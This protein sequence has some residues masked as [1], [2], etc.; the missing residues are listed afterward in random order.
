M[1]LA[2]KQTVNNAMQSGT[3]AGN[4]N[5]VSISSPAIARAVVA[6]LLLKPN[7]L[8]AAIKKALTNSDGSDRTLAAAIERMT[9]WADLTSLVIH[10]LNAEET[11]WRRAALRYCISRQ[12]HYALLKKLFKVSRDEVS[13]IRTELGNAVETRP[14]CIPDSELE[15]IYSAWRDICLEFDQREADRWICLAERFSKFGL[16][17]LHHVIVNEGCHSKKG[18]KS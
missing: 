1:N 11:Q 2:H 5:V 13:R 18:M 12:A 15:S 8:S 17:S 14:K 6:E 7:A 16:N 9:I 4:S 10:G 3:P